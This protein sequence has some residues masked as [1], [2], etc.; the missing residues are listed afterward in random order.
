MV[1][2]ENIKKNSFIGGEQ[3]DDENKIDEILNNNLND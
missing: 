3:E 2:K 1:N